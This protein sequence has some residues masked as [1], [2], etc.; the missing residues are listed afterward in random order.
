MLIILLLQSLKSFVYQSMDKIVEQMSIFH[1]FARGVTDLGAVVNN[2]TGGEKYYT[3]HDIIK[4][5]RKSKSK[6]KKHHTDDFFFL[7]EESPY[8]YPTKDEYE[9]I[10]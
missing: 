8:R 6:S 3:P 9:H 2:L 10:T 1:K 5:G 7:N 4:G